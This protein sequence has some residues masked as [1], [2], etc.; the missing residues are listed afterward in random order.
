[1]SGRALSLHTLSDNP[2]ETVIKVKKPDSNR[3]RDIRDK[4]LREY[5]GYTEEDLV[6]F[7]RQQQ[8][9]FR[10]S[11]DGETDW[12]NFKQVMKWEVDSAGNL[13]IPTPDTLIYQLNNFR[14]Q[15]ALFEI[16][17]VGMFI[18]DTEI[19]QNVTADL[20]IILSASGDKRIGALNDLMITIADSGT[21]RIQIFRALRFL[22][23]ES[24][25]KDNPFLLIALARTTV[26]KSETPSIG[27]EEYNHSMIENALKAT[28]EDFY[29][30]AA[31][32]ALTKVS[33]QEAAQINHWARELYLDSNG[34]EKA[35]NRKWIERFLNMS[36]EERASLKEGDVIEEI[37]PGV[38]V[39]GTPSVNETKLDNL[40]KRRIEAQ[41]IE[42]QINRIGSAHPP[43]DPRS[44]E[45]F[46]TQTD[47]LVMNDAL[48]K[49]KK[50][51]NQQGYVSKFKTVNVSTPVF[52]EANIKGDAIGAVLHII[53][54][55]LKYK[56]AGRRMTDIAEYYNKRRWLQKQI[57]S[58]RRRSI[59]PKP[60]KIRQ[61]MFDVR[62]YGRATADRSVKRSIPA[63]LRELE[64]MLEESNVFYR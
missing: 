52:R 50:R 12:A 27:S 24:G 29:D 57:E 34:D 6:E 28:D 15:R 18:T 42:Q 10:I 3:A 16:F 64:S 62:R 33:R 5:F 51:Q 38:T 13:S 55:V 56:A 46:Q 8:I 40:D 63:T 43:S 1:M 39:L 2:G 45:Y 25:Y 31:K 44:S 30:N 21:S 53:A 37:P 14:E 4:I 36:D 47:K 54:E 20:E 58:E 19:R 22:T 26:Y 61:V 59:P 32:S 7:K 35:L 48:V 23:N 11:Q 41:Q 49:Q 17:K 9:I 60:D